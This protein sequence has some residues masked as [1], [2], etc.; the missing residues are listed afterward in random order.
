MTVDGVEVGFNSIAYSNKT[1]QITT[2]A[3]IYRGQTVVVSYDKSVAGGD[4]IPDS[5]GHEVDSFTTGED[6]VPG[7]VNN[8]TTQL[9]ADATL[10][11]LSVIFSAGGRLR[12][13]L[14]TCPRRSIPESRCT[15]CW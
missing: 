8:S 6:G 4:A 14:P 10:R 13:R 12:W 1:L 5:D 2:A 3:T 9:S 15:A 11:G 7:V